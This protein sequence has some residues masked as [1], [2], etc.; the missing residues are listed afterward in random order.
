MDSLL[1]CGGLQFGQR[2]PSGLYGLPDGY[3]EQYRDTSGAYY[4]TDGSQIYQIDA[5]TQTVVRV[6][7]MSR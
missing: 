7:P 6:Y 1:G 4:R 2:V 3:G 5:R